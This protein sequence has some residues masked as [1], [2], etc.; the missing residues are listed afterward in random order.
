MRGLRY[1]LDNATKTT[2]ITSPEETVAVVVAVVT[3]QGAIRIHR[4]SSGE[5]VGAVGVG[6]AGGLVVV[7]LERTLIRNGF[8]LPSLVDW[9]RMER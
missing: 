2:E 6:G 4:S 7:P 9:L 8:R 5:P 1:N 3:K